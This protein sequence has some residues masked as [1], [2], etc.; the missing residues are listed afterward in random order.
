MDYNIYFHSSRFIEN[1]QN[2]ILEV[3]FTLHSPNG[4]TISS[5][6]FARVLLQNTDLPEQCYDEF[7]SRLN[8]LSVNAEVRVFV[9]N[10]FP[11]R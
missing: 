2:E 8:R 3:E 1:L 5:I 7:L 10:D 4:K 9:K 6:E 11:F